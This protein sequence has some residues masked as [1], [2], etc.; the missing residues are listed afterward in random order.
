MMFPDTT[1]YLQS[2]PGE[3]P[4]QVNVCLDMFRQGQQVCAWCDHHIG[5][6]NQDWEWPTEGWFV[7]KTQA[8][9]IRFSLAWSGS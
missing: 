6:R 2:V 4:Y 3:W 7:F 9:A 5:L 1:F 8:D